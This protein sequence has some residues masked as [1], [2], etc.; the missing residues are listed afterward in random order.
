MKLWTDAPVGKTGTVLV[1]ARSVGD[2]SAIV[3]EDIRLVRDLVLDV[4]EDEAGPRFKKAMRFIL[5]R[6]APLLMQQVVLD[7]DDGRVW[8]AL[9]PGEF[10]FVQDGAGR[11]PFRAIDLCG[12]DPG[13]IANRVDGHWVRP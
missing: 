11:R 4:M 1:A 5:L 7:S 2:L 13:V 10:V 8:R 9:Q 6:V 3:G 12:G